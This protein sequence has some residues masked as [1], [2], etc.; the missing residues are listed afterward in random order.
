MIGDTR[1]SV[2]DRRD[3]AAVPGRTYRT[4]LYV[5]ACG[6]DSAT[7]S[8]AFRTR[9]AALVDRDS[10]HSGADGGPAGSASAEP[11][12]GTAHDPYSSELSPP[13]LLRADFTDIAVQHLPSG[14][15]THAERHPPRV[16]S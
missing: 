16:D 6:R 11:G 13:T 1:K 2:R 8:A 3:D 14:P 15:E 12:V 7:D 10:D 4:A 9:S 5:G